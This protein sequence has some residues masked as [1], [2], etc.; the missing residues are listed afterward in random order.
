[1]LI[2]RYK[3]CQLLSLFTK[4]YIFSALSNIFAFLNLKNPIKHLGG[5]R[6]K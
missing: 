6:E 3:K 1:M 4:K 2:S 5:G